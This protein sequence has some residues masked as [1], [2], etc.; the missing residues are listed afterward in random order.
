MAS[1]GPTGDPYMDLPNNAMVVF[2]A[3]RKITLGRLTGPID[4]A[5]VSDV[6]G[7]K[8]EAVRKHLKLLQEA[9][10]AY[11]W[12]PRRLWP[13]S[14][15]RQTRNRAVLDRSLAKKI[16]QEY[17]EADGRRGIQKALAIKYGVSPQAISDIIRGVTYKE[18]E[19]EDNDSKNT[20]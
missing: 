2:D 18:P 11:W 5:L 20:A 12:P 14:D 3:C 10:L 8:V 13:S 19:S 4:L 16:R 7:L 6:S 17:R 15:E 1:T 9:K